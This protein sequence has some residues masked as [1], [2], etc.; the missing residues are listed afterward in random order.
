MRPIKVGIIGFGTI[1]RAIGARIR[2][3]ASVSD[4]YATNRSGKFPSE[5]HGFVTGYGNH[6][7][8]ERTDVVM[9]CVKPLQ[10]RGVLREIA[11]ALNGDKILVTCA[12][13]LSTVTI[14]DWLGK[15]V[16]VIR[17]MPNMPC[18]IGQGMTALARGH[19]VTSEQLAIVESL[20]AA[21]GR[22]A[23]ID[24]HLM[25]AATAISGC[26]P[27][28]AYLVMEA[29]Y[30]AGV[31]LG[32]PR[33]VARLLVA[34]TT[35]GSAKVLLETD[36]NPALLKDEVATPAGCT[37]EGLAELEEGRIRHAFLR[38]AEAAAK[39]SISLTA[40]AASEM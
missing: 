21:I 27:A 30:E 9:L 2:E 29:L 17:A 33:E 7:T 32:L 4:V 22:I 18:R 12:G 26:G 40:E 10:L 35:M 24:E 1:G 13:S 36:L 3:H 11:A 28:Y 15:A 38:A 39:R 16:P 6:A 5:L 31:R 37:V 19:G 34:Q 8:A 23:L 20:F 14:C 25:N